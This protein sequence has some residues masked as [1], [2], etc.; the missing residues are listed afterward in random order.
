MAIFCDKNRGPC[1]GETELSAYYEP[2]NKKNAC[3]SYAKR[4]NYCIPYN[5]EGINML[6]NQKRESHYCD[7]TI[8]EIEVWGVSFF[9]E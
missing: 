7:F 9:K 5:S 1:F 3:S 6:K 4:Y 8:S 2:F